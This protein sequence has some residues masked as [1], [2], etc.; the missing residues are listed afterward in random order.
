MEGPAAFFYV[1]DGSGSRFFPNTDPDPGKNAFYQRQIKY[2]GNLFSNK[3]RYLLNKK[4]FYGRSENHGK[5][6][7]I[8]DI[9]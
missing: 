2:L 8:V 1:F 3:K 4:C 6:A 9:L 7:Q 5:F